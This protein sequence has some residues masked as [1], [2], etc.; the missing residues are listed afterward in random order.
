MP[1]PVCGVAGQRPAQLA[2][3]VLLA[4]DRRL[5]PA[6]R[7]QRVGAGGFTGV[8]AGY[9]SHGKHRER[10]QQQRGWDY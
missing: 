10:D 4:A 9:P 5:S 1:P 8:S 7:P 2:A 3:D 6:R